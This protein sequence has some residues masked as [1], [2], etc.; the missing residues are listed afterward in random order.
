MDNQKDNKIQQTDQSKT[1]SVSKKTLD[2]IDFFENNQTF[3]FLYKK[4]EKLATA[5]YMITNL[6][7]DSEPMKWSTRKKISD[8]LSFMLTYK[9]LST[10]SKENFLENLRIMV[11]E[12]VS[13]LEIASRSGLLSNM[14]F[15]TL[16]LGCQ[17]RAWIKE[18]GDLLLRQEF[19]F[20]KKFANGF[21]FLVGPFRQLGR[22]VVAD[23]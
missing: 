20:F 6:F 22:F 1:S 2:L 13:L 8:V 23:H 16:S 18:F 12:I 9:N 19:L 7:S 14:N 4:T 10:N 5:L 17:H 11:L 21:V 3:V 15:L